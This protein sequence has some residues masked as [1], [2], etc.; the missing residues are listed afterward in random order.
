[1]GRLNKPAIPGYRYRSP[2]QT[3]ARDL[4]PN[5]DEDVG[6]SQRADVGR[7]QRGLNANARSAANRLRQQEAAGRA[8]IRSAGR[9]GLLGGAAGAGA[10]LG[11]TLVDLEEN[12]REGRARKKLQEEREK[13]LDSVSE[14]DM[15]KREDV[16]GMAKGGKTKAYAKGGKVRGGGIEQ[17]GKTKGRFV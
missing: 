16:V 3:N 14:S 4:T 1:M 6:A 11:S 5:L 8:M 7:M 10:K 12:A 17:R 9:L 2:N 13:E 15:P